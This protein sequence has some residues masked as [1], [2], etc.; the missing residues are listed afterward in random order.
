L[1]AIF[2]CN[3]LIVNSD[4]LA[5]LCAVTVGQC[6]DIVLVKVSAKIIHKA[7]GIVLKHE[8]L[9]TMRL[10]HAMALESVFIATCLLAHLTIPSQLCKPFCFDAVTYGLRGEESATL[11]CLSHYTVP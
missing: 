9:P 7:I 2:T 5:A 10:A 4:G 1:A 3:H 11:F 6:F 8:H